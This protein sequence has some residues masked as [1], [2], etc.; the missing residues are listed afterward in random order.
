MTG[1]LVNENQQK[2]LLKLLY[3]KR[4]SGQP[5]ILNDFWRKNNQFSNQI[6]ITLQYLNKDMG[7][8]WCE[9]HRDIGNISGGIKLTLENVKVRAKITEKGI[10]YYRSEYRDEIW[11]YW[12]LRI[13]ILSFIAS[14]VLWLFRIICHS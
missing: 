12:G 1:S 3:K 13:G 9:R 6:R 11:R 2:K 5:V 14:A 4:K 8:I 10:C 7:Y